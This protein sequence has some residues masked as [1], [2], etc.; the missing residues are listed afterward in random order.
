[1]NSTQQAAT[2][3]PARAGWLRLP[4][5]YLELGKLRL[6]LMVALTTAAGYLLSQPGALDWPR[7]TLTVTGT[8]LAAMGANA[9]NE[10]AE[11]ERD[12]LMHRT[13]SRPIPSGRLSAAHGY[14]AA[15]AMA[16]AG[17][18]LLLFMINPLT[19][20]LALLV[21]AIYV[22]LYTP[23]KTI[24]PTSTLI[25]AIT[26]AIPPLM[27][28]SAA[29]G[30]LDGGAWIMA[31]LLF[32]WQIP[33]FLALAWMF[34]E[35]YERGGYRMLPL[36]DRGGCATCRMLLLYTLAL[37]PVTLA[38]VLAGLAGPA[39][40][41][42]AVLLT[43]ALLWAGSHLARQKSV[44]AARQLFIA[45]VVYL[46]LLLILMVAD[47]GASSMPAGA[48]RAAA[49]LTTDTAR[50]DADAVQRGMMLPEAIQTRW[51]TASY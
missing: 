42:G 33:H 27:G 34:R 29:T 6:S 9:F 51:D 38:A 39:Y 1:M 19:A 12:A 4:G 40:A 31:A 21:Q 37:L 30:R 10:W 44:Q 46:P 36:V 25:G 47:R 3:A 17:D 26:G 14:L 23:L 15:L 7:F 49:R 22:L 24:S 8:L 35:D 18:M 32:F 11:R 20:G 28:F 45:S 13:R 50:Q 41:V 5:L 16:L 48:A 43:L 2:P